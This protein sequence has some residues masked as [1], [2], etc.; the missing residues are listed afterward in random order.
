MKVNLQTQG[1]DLT[2]SIRQH[3]MRQIDFN[4]A[5]FES[6][7][8]SVDVYLRDING[9]K[10]GDDKKALIRVHLFSR[11]TIKVER[12]RDDLYTAMSLCARQAKRTVRRNLGKH[13]NMEKLALRELRQFYQ[14]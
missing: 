13:R 2:P 3:A 6:H 4:L 11:Q 7:I 8:E 12:T 1:F 10:G 14:L 5:I 9:P